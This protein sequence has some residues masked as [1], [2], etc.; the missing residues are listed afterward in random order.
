[1]SQER[2][3]SNAIESIRQINLVAMSL[4]DAAIDV[5]GLDIICMDSGIT[6]AFHPNVY[7]D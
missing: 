4:H 1:M 5:V 6:A 3:Q 7:L 2:D